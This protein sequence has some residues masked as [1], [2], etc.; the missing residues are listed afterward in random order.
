[1]FGSRP[2]GP[3]L[4]NRRKQRLQRHVTP[5]GRHE[6]P[7]SGWAHWNDQD[8]RPVRPIPPVRTPGVSM[9]R[10]IGLGIAGLVWGV[11]CFSFGFVVAIVRR[12]S[13][14]NTVLRSTVSALSCAARPPQ[15]WLAEQR[16]AVSA[17][18]ES[19]PEQVRAPTS[20]RSGAPLPQEQSVA[21]SQYSPTVTPQPQAS[22]AR[23]VY[24]FGDPHAEPPSEPPPPQA[25][26]AQTSPSGW[27]GQQ[28]GA[29]PRVTRSETDLLPRLPQRRRE[30]SRRR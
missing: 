25:P 29:P 12:L 4:P 19:I 24:L 11:V 9:Q 2:G 27:P 3:R 28:H 21:P 16:G 23:K 22:L 20:E 14:E 8:S 7:R 15:P 18:A 17:Q 5:F 30:H 13:D 10:F 6:R 1:M 26:P